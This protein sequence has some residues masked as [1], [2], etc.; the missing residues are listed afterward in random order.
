MHIDTRSKKRLRSGL[1]R[2]KVRVDIKAP[3][4]SGSPV[5]IDPT[6]QAIEAIS[7]ATFTQVLEASEKGNATSNIVQVGDLAYKVLSEDEALESLKQSTMTHIAE[8]VDEEDTRTNV[9]ASQS[10]RESDDSTN[11]KGDALYQGVHPGVSVVLKVLDS[12]AF[13]SQLPHSLQSFI[14]ETVDVI[15]TRDLF[16]Q[17]TQYTFNFSKL[18][19]SVIMQLNNGV[20]DVDVFLLDEQLKALFTDETKGLLFNALQEA[21]PDEKIELNFVEDA[22]SVGSESQQDSSFSQGQGQDE[23]HSDDDDSD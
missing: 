19:L 12:N 1:K 7:K 15:R 3:Q 14:E 10:A 5:P 16:T 18:N 11:Q 20:L 4:S 17:K 22:D 2:L 8:V 21:F 13:I 9:T 6:L 23:D